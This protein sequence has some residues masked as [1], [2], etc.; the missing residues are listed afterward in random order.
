MRI[1]YGAITLF[2]LRIDTA[3]ATPP[4]TKR[5]VRCPN[6]LLANYV[7]VDQT[8]APHLSTLTAAQDAQLGVQTNR[9]KP[10]S[11]LQGNS[12]K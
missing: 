6:A 4:S 1:A 8:N 2:I 7:R 10:R 5:T 11:F 9:F 12:I 3:I